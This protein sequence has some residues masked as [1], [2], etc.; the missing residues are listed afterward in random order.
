MSRPT[1]LTVDDDPQVLA[2]IS[3]DLVTQYGAEYRVVRAS[4][5]PEA[6]GVLSRLHLRAEPVALITAP[7]FST[8]LGSM[9]DIS[10]GVFSATGSPWRSSADFTLSLPSAA[11]TAR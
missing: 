5:G 3:R 2:A 1:I 10:A 9:A 11:A 7:H 6:L 4:S 8:S